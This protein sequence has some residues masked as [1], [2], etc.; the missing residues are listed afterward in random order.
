Y[1]E[2]RR[3][4]PTLENILRFLR[5][6]NA[7]GE[8]IVVDDGSTDATSAVVRDHS[9]RFGAAVT[10]KLMDNP[11]RR[12]KGHA[13][14]QGMLRATGNQ[15]LFTDADLSSPIDECRKLAAVITGHKAAIAFGSRAVEG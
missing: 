4:G 15:V 12:G 8:V 1:N 11:R 7:H 13:V 9:S 5:A 10:L 6:E 14:R 2:A 3:I